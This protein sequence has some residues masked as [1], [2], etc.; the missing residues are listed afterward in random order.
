MTNKELLN[1]KNNIILYTAIP[2]LLKAGF[3]MSPFST[4]CNGR[5]NLNDFSY[6]LC[7]IVPGSILEIIEIYV[8]RDDRWIQFHLNIFKLTPG[9]ESIAQLNNIDGLEY[10]LPPNSITEMRLRSDDIK[11]IPLF[12]LSY[13]N[14][15]KLRRFY[16]KAGL[17]RNVTRLTK[18]VHSDMVN[19]ER[20]VK[21]LHQLHH[22]TKTSWTGHPMAA[23]LS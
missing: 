9:V 18:T 13:M 4:A 22:P 17:K 2:V 14:G 16:T 20:F 21:R 11:G 6:E 23:D 1:I 12:R 7:R 10:K 19:I 3:T 5:N 8:S 15:H